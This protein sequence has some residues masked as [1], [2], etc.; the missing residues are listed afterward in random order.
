MIGVA[1]GASRNEDPVSTG[2]RMMNVAPGRSKVLSGKLRNP[3]SAGAPP[4]TGSNY[5]NRICSVS[6][7]RII[8]SPRMERAGTMRP[9]GSPAILGQKHMDSV[10]HAAMKYAEQYRAELLKALQ[11][12]DLG[13]VKDVIDIF[14]EAR[15]HGRCVFACGCDSVA[16]TSVRLLCDVVRASSVN[17][18]ARFRIVALNDE[19]PKGSGPVE[20]ASADRVF[21]EQ[22]KSI[23]DHGDVIV[24]ISPSGNSPNVLRAFEYGNR[25]GC[26]TI[27]IAGRDGGKLA[28]L[29]DV[30]ILVPASHAASVEDTHMF[31]C[32]MIGNY[33][34]SF[35]RG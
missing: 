16:Q 22:L 23:A 20:G 2:R 26:R 12:I 8:F 32:H 7:G 35:D 21:V 34:V 9:A 11:N 13:G 6:N 5:V 3:L 19:L 28:A 4:G 25:I 1:P 24:G 15:A 18:S 29:S 33:F 14:R 31:I 27:S 17:R 10:Q 30:S